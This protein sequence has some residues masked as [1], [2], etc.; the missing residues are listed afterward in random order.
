MF[1]L[2]L[3][4]VVGSGL[5]TMIRTVDRTGVLL[6]IAT[7][8]GAIVLFAAGTGVTALG[9]RT[10]GSSG[11]A[12]LLFFEIV[13]AGCLRTVVGAI[14]AAPILR[15]VASLLGTSAFSATCCKSTAAHHAGDS[16]NNQKASKKLGYELFHDIAS[17]IFVLQSF[18]EGLPFSF[19]L[20]STICPYP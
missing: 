14:N 7:A 20:H 1:F 6:T 15:T 17:V 10:V 16:N 11:F 19:Y 9:R 8:L 12:L 13:V 18:F 5:G 4:V 2:L 3:E